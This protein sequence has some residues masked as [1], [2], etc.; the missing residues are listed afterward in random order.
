MR[1]YIYIILLALTAACR[2][3]EEIVPSTNTQVTEADPNVGELKGLFLLNEGNMG[4]NKATIDYFDYASGNYSKNIYAERNPTVVKELGDVGNDIQIYEDR[5]YAVINCSNLVEVMD[6]ATAAHIGSVTIPNCRNI[7]F[8]GPYAYVSS[9][10]GAVELSSYSQL[11]YVAKIDLSTLEII[12]ECGVG[13]QPEQM[14]IVDSKLYVANS[15][16]YMYP[17]YD[18]TLSVIDLETF[19]ESHKIE[20]AINLVGVVADDRG[21]LWVSS[22]GDYYDTPSATY[23]VDSSSDEVV[24]MLDVA[25][26]SM[27]LSGDYLYICG[28]DFSYTATDTSTSFTIIDT[29]SRTIID[30]AFIKDNTQDDI[31][32][33][34]CV[35]VNPESGEIFITDAKDYVTPGR[36]HCYSANGELQWSA[37]TG[38]I[39]AHIVFTTTA[40]ESI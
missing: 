9:Y 34:Y 3:E 11:G 20:V 36:L 17:D 18:T 13:Y 23:V 19:V 10:A 40:L 39:P 31:T 14:A 25:N 1:Q 33:P 28:A 37:T 30:T 8:S 29:Q 2:T 16:G 6:V 32:L 22:R 5:L 21:Y 24:D 4:S 35:A 27:A 7:V 26:S 15:G 38:D 12:G